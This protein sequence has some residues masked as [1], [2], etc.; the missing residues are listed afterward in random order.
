MWVISISISVSAYLPGICGN[1]FCQTV[2]PVRGQDKT[3]CDTTRL[4]CTCIY[5]TSVCLLIWMY[6]FVMQQL[7][8]IASLWSHLTRVPPNFPFSV[9]S[10]MFDL[11]CYLWDRSAKFVIWQDC[12]PWEYGQA[13][14]VPRLLCLVLPERNPE[15]GPSQRQHDE[16][17]NAHALPRGSQWT[18]GHGAV[19][20]RIA[21]GAFIFNPTGHLDSL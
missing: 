8:S 5:I 11:I 21:A 20:G 1:S 6:M 12:W 19:T 2:K 18:R 16:L 9:S 15:F 4:E 17:M 3:F 10:S 13:S 7:H 14:H